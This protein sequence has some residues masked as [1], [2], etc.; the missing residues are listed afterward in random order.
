MFQVK[1]HLS[2]TNF[3]FYFTFISKYLVYSNSYNNFLTLSF[4]LPYLKSGDKIIGLQCL[5]KYNQFLE[6][7][8]IFKKG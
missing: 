7:K 6:S 5:K 2:A 1:E 8:K 3:I 4:I